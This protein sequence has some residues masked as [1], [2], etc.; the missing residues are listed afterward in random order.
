MSSFGQAI[1]NKIKNIG[2]VTYTAPAEKQYKPVRPTVRPSNTPIATPKPAPTRMKQYG[3]AGYK[4]STGK[5]V[6]H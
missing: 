1:K 6:G 4:P 5:G 2:S 3:D